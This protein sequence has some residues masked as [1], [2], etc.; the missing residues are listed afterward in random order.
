MKELINEVRGMMKATELFVRREGILNVKSGKLV[1]GSFDL[2]KEW[3]GQGA[4]LTL[5]KL[6][7]KEHVI[8]GGWGNFSGDVKLISAS[9]GGLPLGYGTIVKSVNLDDMALLNVKRA[10]FYV[11]K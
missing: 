9:R 3:G 11:L 1:G 10:P 4:R 6:L 8:V 7:N 5:V 2:E